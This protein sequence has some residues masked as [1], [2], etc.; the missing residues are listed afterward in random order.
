VEPA[1]DWR[2]DCLAKR[3]LVGV[4]LCGV[5]E[6]L[7]SI[8]GLAQSNNNAK[9]NYSAKSVT[10]AA[11]N[12]VQKKQGLGGKKLRK[13]EQRNRKASSPYGKRPPAPK[14][15]SLHSEYCSIS[16]FLFLLLSFLFFTLLLFYNETD[17]SGGMQGRT[18]DLEAWRWRAAQENGAG[19]ARLESWR[20][21]LGRYLFW[22]FYFCLTFF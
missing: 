7:H 5:L 4:E 2:S 1:K 20:E 22:N 9:L 19:D 15:R 13:K 14:R 8:E 3:N 12:K 10:T 6:R 21:P 17:R 11:G 16:S 18:S